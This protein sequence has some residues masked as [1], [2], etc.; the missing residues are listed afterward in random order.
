MPYA[1][2]WEETVNNGYVESV[3]PPE[4]DK[5]ASYAFAINKKEC[6]GKEAEAMF[7]VAARIGG[8]GGVRRVEAKYFRIDAV[9]LGALR[10]DQRPKWLT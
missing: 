2:T 5:L 6:P 8:A 1:R 9:E 10:E 3:L 4:P 7:R